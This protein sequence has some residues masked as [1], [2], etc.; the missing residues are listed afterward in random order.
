MNSIYS[1]RARRTCTPLPVFLLL[2]ITLTEIIATFT[3]E[4][5]PEEHVR[6]FTC[7]K[8]YYRTLHLDCKSD[9]LY[10]GAMDKVFRLNLSNISDS[11]CDKDSLNMV[12]NDPN[13]CIIKGK[14]VEFDCRNH[15]E[16]IQPIGDGNRLYICGTNAYSPKDWMIYTNLTHVSLNEYVPEIGIGKCPYDPTDNSTA[17]WVK[18]GNPDDIPALY[19]GLNADFQKSD[20][21]ISRT[22]LYNPITRRKVY[23]FKRTVSDYNSLNKP[24]F[25]GSFEI[26]L[27]V[28]FNFREVTDEN[29]NSDVKVHSRVARVCKSDKGGNLIMKEKLVT[30]RKARLNCSIPGESPFYFNEIQSIYKVPG[31]D[32]RFYGTFTTPNNGMM[33][34]AICSFHINDIL[35]AFGCEFKKRRLNYSPYF[36]SLSNKVLKPS[37]REQCNRDTKTISINHLFVIKDHPLMES[38]ISQE[39]EKPVFYNRDVMLTK[40]VIDELPVDLGEKYL[41]CTVYYSGS[42]NGRVHKVVQWIDENRKSHSNLLDVFDVTSGEPIQAIEISKK[43]K[44]LYIASDHDIKQIDLVMCLRRYDSCLR[45]VRDPYCGWDKDTNTCKS[46]ISGFLQDVLNRIGTICDRV[47]KC[48]DLT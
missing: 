42:N 39:N 7:G 31:D 41:N 27:Y 16:V 6:E 1:S 48:A 47:L 20:A 45:C 19:S 15:I 12:S 5:L 29:S 40:L 44:A 32:S 43:H 10:V 37:R 13:A 36:T 25:V 17:I 9:A 3:P 35:E 38:V 30:Y 18:N 46:Y 24:N 11:N 4:T 23:S 26:G 21:L 2:L 14:S 33:G 22:D 8:L 34:S 28:F